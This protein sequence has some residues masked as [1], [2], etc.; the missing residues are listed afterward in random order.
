MSD[1]KLEHREHS[2]VCLLPFDCTHIYL[3]TT[4][5]SARR[6]RTVPRTQF[7][8]ISHFAVR[9]VS[10]ANHSLLVSLLVVH[11]ST[12]LLY[13]LPVFHSPVIERCSPPIYTRIESLFHLF[14]ASSMCLICCFLR[15]L[16][17]AFNCLYAFT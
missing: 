5:S 9:S 2:A 4:I 11:S 3:Y 10:D 17:S 12:S 14:S 13:S 6:R 7:K 15:L 16:G 1:S 8:S